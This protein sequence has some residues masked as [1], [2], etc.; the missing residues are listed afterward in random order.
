M[1]FASVM[2]GLFG[3]NPQGTPGKTQSDMANM[4]KM[5]STMMNNKEGMEAFSNMMNPKGKKDTRTTINKSALK[6]HATINR[7]KSKLEKK[8]TE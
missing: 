1:K 6:K 2:P 3:G 5:M 8:N 7:L 4:M